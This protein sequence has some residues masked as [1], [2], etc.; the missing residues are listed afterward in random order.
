MSDVTF[1]SFSVSRSCALFRMH[2]FHPPWRLSSRGVVRTAVSPVPAGAS[3]SAAS[4]R[5]Y[6]PRRPR[7]ASTPRQRRSPPPRVDRAAARAVASRTSC[8]P[9]GPQDVGPPR[10]RAL[11]VSSWADAAAATNAPPTA[12]VPPLLFP[13]SSAT[14]AAGCAG[15]TRSRVCQNLRSGVADK[16]EPH[17]R[18]TWEERGTEPPLSRVFGYCF[19]PFSS[20]LGSR[21]CIRA[22][23]LRASG[24]CLGKLLDFS[25]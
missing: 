21:G 9:C 6:L 20:R 25:L 17:A 13:R 14:R 16:G 11:G 8:P 4:G 3:A 5:P 22:Q 10:P 19:F 24:R 7:A 1:P 2:P 23:G 15:R 18:E 12:Q